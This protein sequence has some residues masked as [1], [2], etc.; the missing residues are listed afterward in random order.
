M[1][2]DELTVISGKPFHAGDYHKSLGWGPSCIDVLCELRG[3]HQLYMDFVLNPDFVHDAMRFLMNGTLDLLVKLESEGILYPNANET[4]IGSGHTGYVD[5]L[6]EQADGA[7]NTAL[8]QLWGFSQAQE[9]VHVSPEMVDEFIYPYQA[10]ILE[11]FGLT[12]YGCC[13]QN[14]NKFKAIKERMP[15]IR[16]IAVSPWVQHEKAV[17][18]IQDNYVYS[19]KP[20]PTSMIASFSEDYIR[21]ETRRVLEITRGCHVAIALRDTQTLYGKPERL[22]AWTR[23]TKEVAEDF[24]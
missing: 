7:G 16:A 5:D 9:L 24:A 20:N 8:K 22:A 6:P 13:E 4:V 15:N 14:D 12:Y 2:G 19:W 18:E 17:E 10:K 1:I 11:L 21:E 3:L 23:I